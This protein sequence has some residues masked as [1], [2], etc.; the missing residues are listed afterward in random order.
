MGDR[1]LVLT[2]VGF[3]VWSSG[4]TLAVAVADR[5]GYLPILLGAAVSVL[6]AAVV[7]GRLKDLPVVVV[8]QRSPDNVP[9]AGARSTSSFRR[10]SNRRAG[11]Q[12]ILG[13]Q[14]R[15]A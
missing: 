10:T 14:H 8:P 5:V 13:R 9:L 12:R 1:D 6:T 3:F 2:S 4:G 7:N 11:L 15:W